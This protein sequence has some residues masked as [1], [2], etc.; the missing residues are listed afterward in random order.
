M[1]LQDSDAG[2]RRLHQKIGLPAG[3]AAAVLAYLLLPSQFQGGTEVV[4]FTHAGRATMSLM[5]W[6]A[7]WWLTEA[8]DLSATALLPLVV[9]PI[10]GAAA[11]QKA[12]APYASELIF[13]FM[14]GFL[15]ALSM[16]RWG[17]DQRIALMTLRLVGTRQHMMVGGFMLATAMMSAFVSNTA[18]AA[19]MLPIG[20]GVI[21]LVRR[22]GAGQ[23]TFHSNLPSP[24]REDRRFATCLMLGIAYSASIGGLATIV[25]SPPNAFVVGFVRES[26]GE[27]I[28]FRAWMG[29]G[30]PLAAVFLVLAWLLLTRV[31]FAVRTSPIEGGQEFLRRAYAALGPINRGQVATF[32][33]FTSAA[34]LWIFRPTLASL[35]IG[36]VAPFKIMGDAGIAITAGVALFVIPMPGPGGRFVMDWK[37]A[38]KLPWGILILF[39]GGLSLADAI[40]TNG[41]AEYIAAHTHRLGT[42]PI[43]LVLAVT[44]IVIFFSELASNT[45][46]TAT[47]VP[48]LAA[49]AV[50]I[51]VDPYLLIVPAALAASCA[52]MMPAGT[53]PNALVFGT[54]QVTMREMIR[55]GLWLNFVGIG[56]ISAVTM[57]II[58]HWFHAGE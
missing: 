20:I 29:F 36:G 11:M 19:M 37:T 41:V 40:Q 1:H 55:A 16:Q 35:T 38:T 45:A 14:G 30:V 47:L 51:G 33:M 32:I 22:Q 42:Q 26:L 4:D 18:T 48:I 9:L 5:L 25:G 54:G 7:T 28:S 21:D 24:S 10:T 39:G 52:F 23:S 8:I 27:Q 57:L 34:L 53:P 17:L 6:M 31:L 15:M 58:R 44:T 2:T 46:T 49:M 50:G 43:V 3:P 56:L 12:A 13:L